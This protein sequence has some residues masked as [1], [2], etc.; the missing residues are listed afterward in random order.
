MPTHLK[1]SLYLCA[2]LLSLAGLVQAEPVSDS[3]R[4]NAFF[5]RVFERNL[6]RS[7]IRQSRMGIK[8]AQD[9]WDDISEERQLEDAELARADL[10]ELATFD[11]ERLDAA[12]KLSYRLFERNLR[13]SL[14]GFQWR[15]HDYLVTQMGGIH[16]R[17]ATTLLTSHPIAE[18]V[19]AEAYI[20]RLERVKPL[21]EQLVVEL[22]RQEAVGVQPPRFVYDLTIGEAGNLVKGRPFDDGADCPMLADFRA[23]VAAA[24]WPAG[25][26]AALVSRAEAALR[27][28]F[29]P[30]YRQLIE[31]L[32]VAQKS[33][34][35]VAGA[36]KLPNGAAFYRYS[37]ESY[38]TLP[39]APD[40]LHELGLKEVARIHAEMRGIMQ[41]LGFS[42]SLQDFFRSVREDPRLYYA[43]TP[44]GREEY[45]A[46]TRKLLDGIRARQ[47]EVLG[48]M[49]K[50]DIVVRPVEP[51]REKS[52]AKAF[53]QGPSEDGSRPGIFFVNL[54]DMHA[55]PRYQLPVVLYHEAIPGHHVE[56]AVAYELPA[57]PRFRKFDSVA[58]FSE[59]WGLYS[60]TLAKEMG[61]Y[62]DPY[63][64]FGRLSLG[65]MRAARLVVDTGL[66][67]KRW[68]RE[69]GIAY[70][71]DNTPG[72]HYDNQREVER[73]IVLPGQATSY[74]V[75]M[76]KIVELRERARKSLGAQFDLRAFHDVVLGSGP[77]PLPILEENVDAWIRAR[78]GS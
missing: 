49:P 27:T 63:D 64:D 3:E 44:T 60:E 59:G 20:A 75:G 61:F 4:I 65:L 9:R 76:L 40:Q 2:L 67:E 43:D 17:I 1:H 36:W 5:E 58:A 52:A 37:L 70:F 47:S 34:T 32:R 45:L 8:T 55:A 69:Q 6:A 42:G 22:R 35:D 46:D 50:A 33:A 56:T 10:R 77:L 68:T 48:L 73:Y 30:G 12:S 51:W 78:R 41:R 71:D 11:F 28:D 72:S 38:T 19:D 15:R 7:P 62:Q 26:Q 24:G 66:H 29:G 18:R 13:E 39:V 16:R 23:K 25:E 57:L 74:A 54:Y 14:Q 21:L 53:Y 31:H